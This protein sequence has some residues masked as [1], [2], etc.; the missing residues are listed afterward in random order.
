MSIS[1]PQINR[2]FIDAATAGSLAGLFA[3][4][5]K[6]TPDKIALCQYDP[7][8]ERWISYSWTTLAQ[9]VA[10]WRA[11]LAAERLQ[12]GDRVAVMLQ[13]SIEWVCFDQ[14]AQSLGLVVVS[15]Y[16]TDTDENI[17]YILDDA[18]VRLLFVGEVEQWRALRSHRVALPY[19]QRVWCL[20]AARELATEPDVLLRW[21]NEVL[22]S[23]AAPYQVAIT[24][25]DAVATLIYT[26][27][28]T[29]RPKGV[30]LTHRNLLSNAEAVQQLIP[31]YAGD[32]FLSFLPLAHGFERT[33]EYLLPMMAGSC[34]T[35]ARSIALLAEDLRV[36]RPTVFISAPR[37]YEKMYGVIQQKLAGHPIKQRLMH[38][39]VS[40]GWRR[41][42]AMQQRRPPLQLWERLLWQ[43]LHTLVA[44][45]VLARLGG[46]LRVAV[47]GAAPLPQQVTRFFLG[48]GLP[49]IE[50][51][52]LTE[53]G[54]V[55]SGNRF[56]DNIAG[57]VG[58]PLV[59]VEVRLA[60]NGEL[61]V[62]SAGVMRGYW[63][64][65]AATH[66]VIDADGWLHTGD[67]AEIKAGHIYIRG[68]LKEILVTS[69]G[70][71]VPPADM[72]AV[73]TLDPL[74]DQA[75]VV[76]E[77]K[78]FLAALL[79]LNADSWHDFAASLRLDP[80]AAQSLQDPRA[81]DAVLARLAKRLSAFPG[82]AQ[83]HAVYLSTKAWSID[84]GLLTP[85]LK[86]KRHTLTQQFSAQ[87]DALYRGHILIEQQDTL[88]LLDES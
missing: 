56:T 85:T 33:V 55:V 83:I 12:P 4:R 26:S 25:P 71:K 52:G 38:W 24:D 19:L 69:T 6:R 44:G 45:K 8:H 31:A 84:N 15:L 46:R 59:G 65:E 10:R 35:Y 17:V 3:E 23:T 2:N 40:L 49:L 30:M 39:T 41:F 57:S 16:T 22:P 81:I 37:L 54:P 14:A 63:Q 86:I 62:R 64:R 29:G 28:T 79:V 53:A 87:I 42:E 88:D 32:V 75:M 61:L 73:I 72:E 43:V 34:V 48:L 70:E 58:T 68:R 36:V 76:G 74:F 1:S 51:Y 18:G 5:V 20:H 67:L 82:Y 9:Q 47:T 78:P 50:G 27:G 77:G 66:Q 80:H 13:N 7:G 21:I 11:A 60:T